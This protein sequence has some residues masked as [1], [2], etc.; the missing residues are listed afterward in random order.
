MFS[1]S[2][3]LSSA[4]VF[5]A[6]ASFAHAGLYIVDPV[7]SSVCSGGKA[8][9]IKWENHSAP[10]ARSFGAVKVGLWTGLSTTQFLIQDLGTIQDPTR[11]PSLAVTIKPAVG[12]NS[13]EYFIRFDPIS[14]KD[15]KGAAL[16][17]FS[18]RFTLKAMT[19]KFSAAQQQA[20]KGVAAAAAEPTKAASATAS[21]SLVRSTTTG[22]ASSRASSAAS[23]NATSS[24]NKGVP[25]IA[26]I[27][28]NAT[29]TTVNT[30]TN[31]TKS[32]NATTASASAK[33]K[34]G[35]EM[36]FVPPGGVL[37]LVIGGLVAFLGILSL[38]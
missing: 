14:G 4:I 25:S 22:G 15:A 11:N 32:N 31:S 33:T 23:R 5:S 37:G 19:G 12:P 36:R 6:L 30:D 9:T 28:A 20:F 8:F 18:S 1:R 17:S 13:D 35:S 3:L 21:T 26:Q 29:G 38:F 2:F 10:S 27:V 16:Q 24:S 34:S 7:A